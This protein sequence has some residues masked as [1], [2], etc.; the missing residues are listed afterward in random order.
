MAQS[1]QLLGKNY[2]SEKPVLV[3]VEGGHISKVEETPHSLQ[4]WIAPALVDLQINGFGGHAVNGPEA[5]PDSIASM[6]ELQWGCGVGALYPTVV[7]AAPEAMLASLKCISRACCD[8][9]IE[10]SVLGIH[11]EG[12]YISAVDGPRGAHPIEHVRPPNWDEFCRFQE[13]AEGRIR[14]V[15][16]APEIEGA[17]PFIER[18]VE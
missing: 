16:L 13:A 1:K 3:E 14:L 17:I 4:L 12:P 8:P 6:V 9:Q 5:T 2:L 18:L 10:R 15:T 11:L 7:T